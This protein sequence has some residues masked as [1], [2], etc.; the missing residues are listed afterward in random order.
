MTDQT[1]SGGVGPLHEDASRAIAEVRHEVTLPA[2]RRMGLSMPIKTLQC[3]RDMAAV[4][5][6]V[7]GTQLTREIETLPGEVRWQPD[8]LAPAPPP[9]DA[10]KWVRE[11][12]VLAVVA[13]LLEHPDA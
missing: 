8:T 3:D 5:L 10:E 7:V 12:D 9:P 4:V 2:Q 1:P 13:A 6:R 11:A